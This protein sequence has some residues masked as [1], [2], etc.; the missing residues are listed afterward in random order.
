MFIIQLQKLGLS[1]EKFYY[2]KALILT[3]SDIR[4]DVPQ[5]LL[6]FRDTIL[7]ALSDWVSVVRP[8]QAMP[9]TPNMVLILPGLRQA[10]W[11]CQKTLVE[12]L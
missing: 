5:A 9:V 11:Y 12:C 1:T 8:G 10:G 3:N 7:N 6:R 2:L 4:L